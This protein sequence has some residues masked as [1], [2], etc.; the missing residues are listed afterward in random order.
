MGRC[1]VQYVCSVGQTKSNIHSTL[2]CGIWLTSQISSDSLPMPI[3][4][5]D[6]VQII[7]TTI[8]TYFMYNFVIVIIHI[9]QIV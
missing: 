6:Q 5:Q 7:E 4:F 3:T 9:T 2:T 8:E 1:E